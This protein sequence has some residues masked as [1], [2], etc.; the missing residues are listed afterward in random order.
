MKTLTVAVPFHLDE[1]LRHLALCLESLIAQVVNVR[2]EI[3]V[4][5]DSATPPPLKVPP[6]RLYHR[7]DLDTFA[8]KL[9]FAFAEHPADYHLVATDDVI[10]GR[11]SVLAMIQAIDRCAALGGEV[12]V[13]C[14]SNCDD[15]AFH[16]PRENFVDVDAFVPA[17]IRNVMDRRG[18]EPPIFVRPIRVALYATMIPGDVWRRLGGLDERFVN[19]WEDTDFCLRCRLAHVVPIVTTGGYVY[20]GGSQTVSKPGQEP[21]ASNE[22]WFWEKWKGEML[23]VGLACL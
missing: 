1:N 10:F 12:I 4:V 3:V 7:P 13:N 5:S 23:S 2:M 15:V 9:N 20:H 8:K 14:D 16:R 19:S 22:A 18:T 21:P 11:E 17:A 6:L